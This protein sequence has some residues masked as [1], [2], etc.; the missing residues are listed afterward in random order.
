MFDLNAE[1]GVLLRGYQKSYLSDF[2]SNVTDVTNEQKT[3]Q[4]FRLS[5]LYKFG[6]WSA[7]PYY[8]HWRIGNSQVENGYYEPKNTTTEFGLTAKYRY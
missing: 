1:L 8:N 2:Y 5:A 7:G 4:N 6:Q 3:G